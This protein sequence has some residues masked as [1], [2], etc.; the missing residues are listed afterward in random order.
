M[1]MFWVGISSDFNLGYSGQMEPV[2]EKLLSNL[3]KVKRNISF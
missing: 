2:R 1:K 3:I